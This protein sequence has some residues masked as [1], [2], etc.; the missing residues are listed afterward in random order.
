MPT[1][2]YIALATV[3]LSGSAT[4]VTFGSI[5]QNYRDLILIVNG[6]GTGN[7]EMRTIYNS[8][9]GSNYPYVGVDGTYTES[10][11]AVSATNFGYFTTAQWFHTIQV[12]DYSATNKRKTTLLRR[13]GAA[14]NSVTMESNTWANNSAINSISINAS[15]NA[16][17]TG[18]TF[19]LYGIGS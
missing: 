10:G 1:P 7:L 3:T 14:N 5:P 16:F 17:A 19:N 11:V 15:A 9:S 18:T 2:S 6:S 12:F 4:S 13:N 8:D